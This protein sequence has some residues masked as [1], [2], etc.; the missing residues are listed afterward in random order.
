MAG[1]CAPGLWVPNADCIVRGR[2]VARLSR[3]SA[4]VV[5]LWKYRRRPTPAHY[6]GPLR[7]RFYWN[8]L[9]LPLIPAQAEIQNDHFLK[10]LGPA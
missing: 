9:H 1:M 6:T 10:D 8:E 5:L 7:A 3:L 2:Y 4:A